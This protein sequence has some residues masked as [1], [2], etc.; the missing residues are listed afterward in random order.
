MVPSYC[1]DA[2]EPRSESADWI[3][4]AQD[5]VQLW[6]FMNTVMD[7]YIAQKQGISLTVE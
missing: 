1:R 7:L 4:L 6:A 3:Q 2:G 5:K